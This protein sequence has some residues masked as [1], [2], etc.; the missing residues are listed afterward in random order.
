[1]CFPDNL[2]FAPAK[3]IHNPL[4]PVKDTI[5]PILKNLKLSRRNAK[6][7]FTVS[8]RI[9]FIAYGFVFFCSNKQSLMKIEKANS[10]TANINVLTYLGKQLKTDDKSLS[11]FYLFSVCA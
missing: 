11:V 2:I 7:K 6:F 8:G 5:K 1:M 10:Y 9:Y 4:T 3:N